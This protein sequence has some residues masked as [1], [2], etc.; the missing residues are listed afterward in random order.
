MSEANMSTPQRQ[1]SLDVSAEAINEISSKVTKLVFDYFTGVSRL[2]VFAENWGGKTTDEVEAELAYEG[3]PLDKLIAEC[4]TIINLSRHNGHPRFFGYVASPSTPIGAY[5]DLITSALNA[6]ITCWRSGPAGTEIEKTVVR[7]L[8]ALIGYDENA[9]GLLT[10]GGSMANL[11]ALLIASRTKLGTEISQKG[12][13]NSG[14]PLTMYASEEIHMS[15]AKAA[16]VLG[17]GREQVR[18]IECDDQ[19]RMNVGSLREQI[20]RDLGEGLRPFCV[21]GS[22]GTVNTGAIDPLSEI[23][24]VATQFNLWFH[25]DG[26]Y[27][28]PGVLDPRKKAHFAGL[29][30]ADS[31][32]LDP[33]KWLYV[34]VDAGCLL[35]RD[36][37]AARATFSAADA[38]YIKVHG[39]TNDEAFAFWDYGV[40]L[41]RRFRALKIWLTL[42]YYGVRRIAEAISEDNSL[43]EYLA[44]VV[45]KAEDLELLAPVELSI[46]CFRYVPADLQARLQT[47]AEAERTAINHEL[48][49]LNESVM[50]AVQ[51]GG[52]AYLS[53]ATI[54]GR[55]ALRVCI[56]NFRTTRADIDQTVEIVRAAAREL[57]MSDML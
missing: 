7:W 37:A 48:D 44:A 49:R 19:M 24:R 22:A 31:V 56:T 23:A 46:C 21:A 17:L 45:Q 41:S 27:G 55:F 29:E 38:D 11:I 10:S 4:R 57:E 34:P 40:E 1:S 47:A 53:N 16:D 54:H 14:A 15:I 12:L 26:A 18:L 5:A 33:H 13:W 2:P 51:G 36:E 28:A 3:V 30:R 8:G 9:H 25:V 42:R 39:H 52:K 20:I 6:N 32:S 50:S 35:F 43:A